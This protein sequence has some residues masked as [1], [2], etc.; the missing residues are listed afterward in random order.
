MDATELRCRGKV[1][2]TVATLVT[3]GAVVMS[4][5][6]WSESPRFMCAIAYITKFRRLSENNLLQE[7]MIHNIYPNSATLPHCH[8]DTSWLVLG[9]P[10]C[11]N[12]KPLTGFHHPQR[13]FSAHHLHGFSMPSKTQHPALWITSRCQGVPA[14]TTCDGAKTLQIMGKST[15]INWCRIFFHPLI[16]V[17]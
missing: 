14:I 11:L 17:K 13:F 15:I 10:C 7:L 4:E 3:T 6:L 8:M 12:E 16:R 2:G 9:A 1:I 5:A